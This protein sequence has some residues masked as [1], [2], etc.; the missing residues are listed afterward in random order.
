MKTFILILEI[1][2]TVAFAVSGAMVGVKKKMDIFGVITLGVITAVGGG[3]I[4]DLVLG[5]TPPNVFFHPVYAITAII[6]SIIMFLSFTRRL[7]FKKPHFYD[8][9]MLILDSVGLGIFTVVGIQTAV[10]VNPDYP[11]LLLIFVGMITGVGGG[12]MRDILACEMPSI[13]CKKIY[14]CASLA[15]AVICIL[16]IDI[17]GV[18]VA[19]AIGAITVV[20][21]RFLAAKLHWSLPKAEVIQ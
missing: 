17:T 5:Q 16:L 12:V 9:L 13:L 20:M 6:S 4:R 8:V 15:G 7:L 14:A 21:I 18:S 2:G 19:M 10:A 3:V 11:T 1:I